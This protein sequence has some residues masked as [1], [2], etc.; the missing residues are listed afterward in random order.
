M[1]LA[2]ILFPGL[3]GGLVPNDL[4]EGVGQAVAVSV[5]AGPEGFVSGPLEDRGQGVI[6][7]FRPGGLALLFL[8]VFL[9]TWGKMPESAAGH[10]HGARGRTDGSAHRSHMVG[11]IEHH[12]GG[13]EFVKVGGLANFVPVN[14]KGVRGLVISQNEKDVGPLGVGKNAG[15]AKDEGE[16]LHSAGLG[17]FRGFVKRLLV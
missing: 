15:Q 8:E 4:K 10:D 16:E 13:G 7:D 11:L 1:P 9:A 2:A 5:L 17:G 3:A 14:R 6:E 12:S